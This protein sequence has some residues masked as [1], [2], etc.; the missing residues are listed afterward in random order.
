MA[1]NCLWRT[2][3][4]LRNKILQKKANS[5]GAWLPDA[6]GC[7]K[8]TRV[9]GFRHRSVRDAA[10]SL[11]HAL[12]PRKEATVRLC[13]FFPRLVPLWLGPWIRRPCDPGSLRPKD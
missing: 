4:R 2:S 12:K 6:A 7:L 9:S 1:Q 10:G 13:M 3:A 8:A 11:K 5:S